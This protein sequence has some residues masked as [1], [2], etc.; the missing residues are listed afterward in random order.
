MN[1]CRGIPRFSTFQQIRRFHQTRP[2]PFIS[3]VLDVSSSFI[4]GVH[5]VSHLPWALSLP[6]TAF[7]V[8]MGVA[9]PL[10]IFTKVQARKDSDLTPILMAWRHLY[11]KKAIKDVH[12]NAAAG[13]PLL[14][15]E[16][17][18]QVSKD[19]FQQHRTL[20]QRWGVFRFYK[21]AAFLQMP[22]WIMI[23]ES[24]RGMSGN[25]NGLVPY[26]LS[27]VSSSSSKDSVPI[28]PV[29]PTLATE[30][31]LWF[32]DLLA[33]DPTGILPVAMTLSILLNI[34]MGWKSPTLKN[35]SNL[36][37]MEMVRELTWR[38]LK[39]FV[40]ILALNIG[41]SSYLYQ[42]PAA[43]MIY[44]ITSA[45]IATLQTFLLQKYM[46]PTPSLKPWKKVNI[47]YASRGQKAMVQN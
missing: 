42:M 10:Q 24:I 34:R 41:L 27:I 19:T 8:R 40:Q 4:H 14:R 23:M 46:F 31:A 11:Q 12:K 20:R 35:I 45:N 17:V 25:N 16:A 29:E 37:R 15:S 26:L 39:F 21:P 1:A 43:L 9:L 18:L 30:G 38:G 7:L 32:P 33:G 6:L 3:E 47:G 36:P 5:S 13:A 22:V 44:W 28:I 2:A